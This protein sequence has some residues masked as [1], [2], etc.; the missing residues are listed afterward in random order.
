MHW[1][2]LGL[3]III[4]LVFGQNCNNSV[5]LT[6]KDNKDG[7]YIKDGVIYSGKH[8]VFTRNESGILKTFGCI[9]S[10]T[11]C[12]RKCCPIGYVFVEKTCEKRASDD[13]IMK[14]GLTVYYYNH[15][16]KIV[17]VSSHFHLVFGR[18]CDFVYL[19]DEGYTYTQEVSF[20]IYCL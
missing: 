20:L 2:I 10:A 15:P 4:S 5:E 6:E 14:N 8:Q 9:C 7:V 16:K 11:V 3:L 17:N 1:S 12:F 13:L 18:P 19:E